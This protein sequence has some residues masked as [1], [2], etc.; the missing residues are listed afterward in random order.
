MRRLWPLAACVVLVTGCTTSPERPA[1]GAAAAEAPVAPLTSGVLHSH[2][3]RSVEPPDD[4]YRH[5]NGGWLSRNE[6]PA[7]KSNYG[8]FTQ[9]ADQAERD[10]RAIIEDLAAQTDVDGEAQQ[11]GALYRSFMDAQRAAEQGLAP[12]SGWL[13]EID[14]LEDRSTLPALLARLERIGVRQPFAAF[15]GQDAK[16]ARQYT[17]YYHQFDQLG[18]PD[19][20]YY[21]EDNPRFIAARGAYVDY[22][23]ALLETAGDKASAARR[24]AEAILEMETAVA[25]AH[26]TRVDA[27]DDEKTYHPVVVDALNTL[28]PGFDFATFVRDTG[29]TVDTVI[30]MQPEAITAMAEALTTMPL[31]QLKALLKARL[32]GSFAPYLGPTF[33]AIDFAYSGK[34]LRGIDE[35]RARWKRGVALVEGALGEAVGKRYVAAH[36][37]PEAKARMQALVDHLIDAYRDSIQSLDWMGDATK[38]RALEKMGKFTPKIGYPSKWKDYSA[39]V[40]REDDLVG[41]VMRSNAL[42]HARQLAKLG[43]PVDREEWFMT[44]QT[45]NA[46]YN[47]SLNEIVFPAAI[48]QPP[49]F[50]LT[51]EDA[52]NF[53][54]IGAVIGHEIGHGF[55]DQGS[56]Y[57]GDGNLKSWWTDADRAAFETR[58]AQLIEQYNGYCPLP[59]H[60]VNGALSIGEN[61]GDLGGVSIALKAYRAS[62]AGMPSPE[63]DG[64][65]GTQR[66]FIGW[67]QVW[68]RQHREEDMINRLKTGPH[69]PS[70]YRTNGVVRNIPDWYEAFD[71]QPDDALWLP[72]EERVR[73]W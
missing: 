53:G 17:V 34:A 59:E 66:F 27:R 38:Q 40:V 18:L 43:K 7:D 42:E 19:R 26:W 60:C 67:A 21:L 45:V 52:V 62:L 71:V 47:P 51:A 54:A 37:P 68:A 72:P 39:L 70:E 50:D 69:A 35:Q 48:L 3:D 44:P 25:A 23:A 36:F 32:L 46:Y 41:N 33:E 58:T 73:I 30:V 61:I 14:D 13:A 65:T 1:T 6:I 11:I 10:L 5:V 64:F 16:D 8:V 56:K 55:D 31:P 9:L 12:L 15:I 29:V 22:L 24:E 57:D 4:F 63:I 28:T 49:F 2:F 20:S